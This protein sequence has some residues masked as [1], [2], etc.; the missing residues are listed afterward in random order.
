M[1]FGFPNTTH[2]QGN[3]SLTPSPGACRLSDLKPGESAVVLDSRWQ[4]K[5]AALLSSYGFFPGSQVVRVGSAPQ[6]DPLIFRLDG[7]L[8]AVRSETAAEIEVRRNEQ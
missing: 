4:S 3:D 7:R 5:H 2:S 6:G 8:V 1:K